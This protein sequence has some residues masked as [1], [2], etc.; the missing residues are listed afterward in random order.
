MGAEY[1]FT[2]DDRA[3]IGMIGVVEGGG[4]L[5]PPL[6]PSAPLS[7]FPPSSFL[8]LSRKIT[9]C[10]SIDELESVGREI[11]VLRVCGASMLSSCL[12]VC[13]HCCLHVVFIWMYVGMCGKAGLC[14]LFGTV[15]C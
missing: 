8:A 7:P 4:V 12:H 13:K 10:A 5:A 14:R 15:G 3:S 1:M 6:P 2:S 9:L 11:K